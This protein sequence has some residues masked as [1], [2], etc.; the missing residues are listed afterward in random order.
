L[1]QTRLPLSEYRTL[2]DRF[3]AFHKTN[4]DV[5][6]HLRASALRLKGIGHERASITLLWE[7][8]RWLEM[9]STRTHDD[10]RKLNNNYK[11]FYARMLMQRNHELHGFFE[12]RARSVD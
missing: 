5:Y 11:P 2:E 9:L 8:L 10:T 6:H 4:P 7:R 1:E 12:T 3:R